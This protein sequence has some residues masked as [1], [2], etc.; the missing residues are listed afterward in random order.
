MKKK[1]TLLSLLALLTVAFFSF[2]NSKGDTGY[3]NFYLKRLSNFTQQQALLRTAIEQANLT[4]EKDLLKIKGQLSIAR[5][6]MKNVDFWFRYLEPLAYKKINSPLPVEWET[7]VFEKFEKPYKREGAGLTLAELYLDE[8]SISKDTLLSLITASMECTEVFSTDSIV[9]QLKDF[10][11]FYLC[12]R[13]YLL[14]LAT[15]YTTGFECPDTKQI[16]PELKHMLNDVDKMYAAFNLS[17]PSTAIPESY[18][19]LHR[20]AVAFVESQTNDYSSFDH[21]TFIKDYVNPLFQ[22]NQEYLRLYRVFSKSM[23][24]Y[25]LNKQAISIF[26][27]AL[28]NGQ[29]TKGIYLRVKDS[30]ALATID[31]VGKLLFFD[32]ILSGNNN[33]S[34]ASCHKPNDYFTDN[35]SSTNR[36][37]N[38]TGTLPRNTP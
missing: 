20:E 29:N 16:V 27:K 25:S 30:A 19:T 38:Q 5:M 3:K 9:H 22:L 17:F 33:R 23:M 7:E 36:A 4:D 8:E 24:D 28:Y 34:C 26:D 31:H 11:H 21:F 37:F 35:S 12:N 6:A 2:D 18:L 14:N 13:L 10:N 1:I 32:P 15:I